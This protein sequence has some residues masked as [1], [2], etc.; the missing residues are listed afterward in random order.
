MV[1]TIGCVYESNGKA[2]FGGLFRDHEG[3]WLLGYYGKL[4]SVSVLEAEFWGIYRGLTIMFEKGYN[5]IHIETDSLAAVQLINADSTEVHP[6]STLIYD[7]RM[8]LRH[9]QSVIS[10]IYREAN[11]SADHLARLGAEQEENLVVTEMS[12]PSVRIFV[13]DDWLRRSH[14]RD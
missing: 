5:N 3:K 4:N 9:T 10:H 2:G 11:S 14:A 8:L 1:N 13:H 12:P 6:N 7:S